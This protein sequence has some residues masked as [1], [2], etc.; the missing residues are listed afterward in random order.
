MRCLSHPRPRYV[1]DR[2]RYLI[3]PYLKSLGVWDEW[4]TKPK[5]NVPGTKEPNVSPVHGW[6]TDGNRTLHVS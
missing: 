6:E 5:C 1:F 3:F 4:I 2:E